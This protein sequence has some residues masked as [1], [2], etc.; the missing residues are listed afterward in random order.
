MKLRRGG[1]W[2][3]LDDICL[4]IEWLWAMIIAFQ[5]I[6]WKRTQIEQLDETT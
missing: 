1:L 3:D 4:N 2:D 5:Y 6:P